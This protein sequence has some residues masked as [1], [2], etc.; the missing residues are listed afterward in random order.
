V[1]AMSKRDKRRS[2]A[3]ARVGALGRIAAAG[4][5]MVA[6]MGTAGNAQA[7]EETY[8]VTSTADPGD[9]VCDGTCTLREAIAAAD[10]DDPLE[11]Q[12]QILF[13]SGLSGT[14]SLGLS[15]ELTIDEPLAIQGPG[16]DALTVSGQDVTRILHVIDADELGAAVGVSGLTLT[17]GN[18]D[19]DLGN[20]FG[21]A[22]FNE[23]AELTI[24]SATISNSHARDE[25]AGGAIAAAGGGITIEVSR[26]IGNSSDLDG[27]AIGAFQGS[28]TDPELTIRDSTISGNSTTDDMADGGAVVVSG[29]TTHTTT[30]ERS[31]ISGNSTTGD[32]APGGALSVTSGLTTIRESTISGNSTLG[33]DSDGGGIFDQGG[34]NIENS[35]ISGN[36]AIGANSDGGGIQGT[37]QI[38]SSTIAGNSA[39]GDGGGVNATGGNPSLQNTIV[40]D[41]SAAGTGPDLE[42]A[43]GTFQ[44]SFSLIEDATSA[45]LNTTVAG[46]NIL[47]VDPQL[48]LLQ[49]NGGPTRTHALLPTSPTVDCGRAFFF[50]TTDQRGAGFPRPVDQP[51]RANS[52]AAGADGSDMGAFELQGSAAGGACPTFVAPPAPPAAPAA[53]TPAAP[54]PP[55]AAPPAPTFDLQAAIK[56]CRKKHPKGPKRKRCIRKARAKA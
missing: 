3:A 24:Q 31:T 11:D 37:P 19:G 44:V 42:S 5:A 9:G 35:T 33:D 30:I 27:G 32:D 7:A 25:S 49:D 28:L 47:G 13:Q 29:L 36:S 43:S 4:L 16:A 39:E 1:S 54:L 2:H 48:G 17:R 41:N 40:S 6:V 23:G 56:R 46:S 52:S 8:T 26:I 14:I 45:P 51:G 50:A 34:A 53:P 10:D 55:A 20:F 21:G 22:I 12:D 38:V 15:G 18:A